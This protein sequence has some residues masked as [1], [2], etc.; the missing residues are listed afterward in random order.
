[1]S[2]VVVILQSLL[3]VYYLFSGLAK[4][5]G[6]KYWIDIFQHLKLSSRFRI[7][8]GIVQLAGAIALFAGYWLTW[9]LVIGCIWLGVTMVVACSV[10]IRVRD[11][12]GK[13]MPALVFTIIIVSLLCMQA[14][15]MPSLF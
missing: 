1:M 3:V 4:V 10:H 6:A 8:T 2:I 9:S 14:V 13:T 12:L 5:F 7:V 15:T 11:S